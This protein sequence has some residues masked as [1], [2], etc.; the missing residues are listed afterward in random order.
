MPTVGEFWE[1]HDM[2]TITLEALV[3][4]R[5]DNIHQYLDSPYFLD[6]ETLVVARKIHRERGLVMPED[7]CTNG[8]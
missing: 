4:A 8:R 7:V 3:A 2:L 5:M 1:T 6:E